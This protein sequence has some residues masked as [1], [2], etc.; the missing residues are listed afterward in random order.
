M[1]YAFYLLLDAAIVFLLLVGIIKSRNLPHS[2]STREFAILREWLSMQEAANNAQ[3]T[4]VFAHAPL[5]YEAR[6]RFMGAWKYYIGTTCSPEDREKAHADISSDKCPDILKAR[7]G[8]VEYPE[9]RSV[10]CTLCSKVAADGS[11]GFGWA[12]ED[13]AIRRQ[14]QVRELLLA[15][16]AIKKHG[17]DSANGALWCVML[18]KQG[19]DL[20]ARI[21]AELEAADRHLGNLP[22]GVGL[23]HV[24]DPAFAG[25][26]AC[27]E[28]LAREVPRVARFLA[29]EGEFSGRRGRK[30]A[31]S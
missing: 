4:R 16:E 17:L 21:R 8:K 29:R 22:E 18:Q 24:S 10:E 14:A 30:R 28:A 23:R 1:D 26:E 6:V 11:P 19:P 27:A 5:V 31:A 7:L 12:D 2:S 9:G 25:A 13:G 3:E 20:R 15:H